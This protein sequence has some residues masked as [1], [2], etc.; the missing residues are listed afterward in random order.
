MKH[1]HYYFIL[2]AAFMGFAHGAWAE[3]IHITTIDQLNTV[4]MNVLAGN[5]YSG[6][7]ICLDNDLEFDGTANNFTPIGCVSGNSKPFAGT[8]DE[9]G[10]DLTA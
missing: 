8:F 9:Q 5:S 6:D 4:A 7:V 1:I 10:L 2:L 3:D